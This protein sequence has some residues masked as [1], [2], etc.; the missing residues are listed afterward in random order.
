MDN[1]NGSVNEVRN[2]WSFSTNLQFFSITSI[3]LVITFMTMRNNYV[4]IAFYAFLPKLYSI[5]LLS[6]LNG[7]LAL[8]DMRGIVE[9]S[10]SI[11]GEYDSSQR[12]YPPVGS[13]QAV[14]PFKV[15]LGKAGTGRYHDEVAVGSTGEMPSEGV[16]I[17]VVVTRETGLSPV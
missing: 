12:T 10:F 7:R 15:G 14:T 9:M 5:S 8:R 3:V 13:L 6:T 4:W 11:G 16:K 2:V 1:A 17:G